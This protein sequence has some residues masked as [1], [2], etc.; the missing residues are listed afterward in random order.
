M[1]HFLQMKRPLLC[2]FAYNEIIHPQDWGK[3]LYK[4]EYGTILHKQELN[5][6]IVGAGLAPPSSLNT[7]MSGLNI[8]VSSLL[9]VQRR[10]HTYFTLQSYPQR[11]GSINHAR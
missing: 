2:S 10:T 9:T 4:P 1:F 7:Y 11:G 5:S 3:S 8:L 6:Y